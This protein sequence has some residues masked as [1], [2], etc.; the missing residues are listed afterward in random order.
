VTTITA[1]PSGGCAHD[2][3]ESR[4][5]AR[6]EWG[7]NELWE[8]SEP[9]AGTEDFLIY[10]RCDFVGRLPERVADEPLDAL[11]EDRV[12]LNGDMRLDELAFVPRV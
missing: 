1:P 2:P 5:L 9:V 3:A 11:P 4:M 12:A 7:F 6:G 10:A 8:F